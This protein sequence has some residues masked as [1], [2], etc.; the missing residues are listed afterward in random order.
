MVECI[1]RWKQ[2]LKITVYGNEGARQLCD[3]FQLDGINHVTWPAD[4]YKRFGRLPWW[5]VQTVA[6]CRGVD[7]LVLPPAE[8]HVIIATSEF[9]PNGMPFPGCKPESAFVRCF[10]PNDFVRRWV[11]SSKTGFH[12]AHF[13]A[14]SRSL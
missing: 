6:G 7:R 10:S 14:V 12:D 9:P 2:Q 1:R 8:K 4:R 3:H 13:N 11:S 5:L